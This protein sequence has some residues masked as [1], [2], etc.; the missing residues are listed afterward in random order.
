MYHK[1]TLANGLRSMI[2]DMPHMESV[3]LA[4]WIGI[5]GRFENKYYSD[6]TPYQ[7]HMLSL[8]AAPTPT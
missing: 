5:G 3:A 2:V 1:M 6:T 4:V 8:R 7:I